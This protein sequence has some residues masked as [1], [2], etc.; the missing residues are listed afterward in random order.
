VVATR[1]LSLPSW[2]TPAVTFNNTTALPLLLVQSFDATGI[3]KSILMSDTDTSSNA[4]SRAKSYFLVNA[5][6]SSALTFAL[7][8][9]LLNGYEEDPPDGDETS[10]EDEAEETTDVEEG[11]S[12]AEDTSQG[13]EPHEQTT[14]LPTAVQRTGRKAARKTS[15]RV[16]GWVRSLPPWAQSTL[17]FLQQ[18]L[19]APVIGAAIGAV[20]GLVPALHTAF[21]ADTFHGGIF[22]AWLTA[23]VQNIGDLF[24]SLQVVV[25]GVKLS[26]SL[27]RMKAGE[28][29]GH[30]PWVALLFVSLVRFVI[31]PL[32]SIPVIWALATKTGV[33][34]KDPILWFTMMLMPA[35][36]PAM[37]LTSLAEVSGCSE[38]DLM[39]VSK[40]LTVRS[41]C[42]Y[43]PN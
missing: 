18:F 23:S 20:I 13:D 14:L 4:V 35:G 33:L 15:S 10:D 26:K 3:L 21:F 7:G 2:V 34:G 41:S 25:T 17:H 24:A 42:N 38:K 29:S 40:F 16:G 8:P 5:M 32:I 37:K 27:Q 9:G 43:F 30:V 19:N 28:E 36:P 22:S 6:I 39:S 12:N 11:N 31:W 1:L